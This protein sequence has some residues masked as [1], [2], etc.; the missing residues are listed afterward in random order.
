MPAVLRCR[1]QIPML[2]TCFR[3]MPR[4]AGVSRGLLRGIGE[5]WKITMRWNAGALRIAIRI[6]ENGI[7]Q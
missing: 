6:G 1:L 7:P 5:E 4:A 3:A 2:N